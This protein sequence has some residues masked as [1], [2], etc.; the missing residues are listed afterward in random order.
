MTPE[1]QTAAAHLQSAGVYD[2]VLARVEGA[3]FTL[4]DLLG[5]ARKPKRLVA[6]RRRVWLD[7]W[8]MRTGDDTNS[9]QFSLH[10]MGRMFNREHTV[11]M[12]GLCLRSPGATARRVAASARVPKGYTEAVRA[13][14]DAYARSLIEAAI[15]KATH[16]ADVGTDKLDA[17]VAA[18]LGLS[19]AKYRAEKRRLGL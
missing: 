2:M 9:R 18:K 10:D 14:A 5:K 3:S 13:V 12:H 7:V 19:K 8:E 17:H 4:E 11:I 16:H 1:H 6:L 15:K